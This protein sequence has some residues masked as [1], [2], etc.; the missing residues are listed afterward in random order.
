LCNNPI[1]EA[2]LFS[3]QYPSNWLVEK[4]TNNYS[5]FRLSK[6]QAVLAE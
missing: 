6:V 4:T 5:S 3:L 1:T 2:N